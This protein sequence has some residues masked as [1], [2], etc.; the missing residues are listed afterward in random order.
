MVIQGVLSKSSFPSTNWSPEGRNVVPSRHGVGWSS[1][2]ASAHGSDCHVCSNLT[3]LGASM[4]F[5]RCA[6]VL[7]A[8]TVLPFVSLQAAEFPAELPT[9]ESAVAED[10]AAY[11]PDALAGIEL[12]A[13]MDVDLLAS[14]VYR[15]SDG[16]IFDCEFEGFA[17]FLALM[18]A[19]GTEMALKSSYRT[20]Q[21]QGI[22]ASK[23]LRRVAFA[24]VIFTEFIFISCLVEG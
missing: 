20:G 23:I 9:P 7:F 11:M 18:A 22:I 8:L 4:N 6:L 13:Y 10:L 19:S 14:P 12:F 24:S 16:E 15:V 17:F 3:A 21:I 5:T 1:A 2:V